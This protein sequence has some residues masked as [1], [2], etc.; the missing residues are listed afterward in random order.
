MSVVDN[1]QDAEEVEPDHGLARVTEPLDQATE[2]LGLG[3]GD[4]HVAGYPEDLEEW[5]EQV[6]ECVSLC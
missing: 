2:E 6:L 5:V 1:S 4:R 3:D